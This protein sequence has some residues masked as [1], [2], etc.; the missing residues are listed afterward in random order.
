[1]VL[2]MWTKCC[3]CCPG[4]A[5]EDTSHQLC[6]GAAAACDLFQGDVWKLLGPVTAFLLRSASRVKHNT[7]DLA[8]NRLH[9][10]QKRSTNTPEDDVMNFKGVDA[11]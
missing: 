1:M 2:S 6:I 5:A 4:A 7:V 8:A 9:T 11:L 10:T 3:W